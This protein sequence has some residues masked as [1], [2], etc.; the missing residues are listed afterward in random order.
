MNYISKDE[1]FFLENFVCKRKKKN[2]FFQSSQDLGDIP[3]IKLYSG[4]IERK[5][6]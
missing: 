2:V 6:V 5:V 3:R 1:S 4:R